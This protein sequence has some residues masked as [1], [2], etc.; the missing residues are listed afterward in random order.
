MKQAFYFCK[1]RKLKSNWCGRIK[2][3]LIKYD[4][5]SIWQDH[6]SIWNLDGKN[7]NHAASL[8]NHQNFWK[9]FFYKKVLV[10]EEKN[11]WNEV[12]KKDKLGTYIIFKQPRLKLENYL[13]TPGYYYSRSILTNIRIGTNKLEIEMGRREKIEPHL[14]FCKQ[15]T[16][17]QPED[18][19]HFI[20]SCPHYNALRN[21]LFTDIGS[22]SN[23]KWNI[24]VFNDMERFC[25]LLNGS[26]DTYESKIFVLVRKYLAQAWKSR[27]GLCY[28]FTS[29]SLSIIEHF[30]FYFYFC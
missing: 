10:V 25:F 11:W 26:M 27:K 24:M 4:L 30:Y 3:I 7:N 22:I 18:E 12:K 23:G 8:K 19:L 17:N 20:I 1:E 21:K 28:S 29:M 5:Y 14:R 2:R 9:N 6:N 15:C 13:L 16:L